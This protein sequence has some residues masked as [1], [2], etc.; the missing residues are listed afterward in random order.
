[1]EHTSNFT[2]S[3]ATIIFK[4]LENFW[5]DFFDSIELLTHFHI[6]VYIRGVP[7][8]APAGV[9]A[10]GGDV[11]WILNLDPNLSIALSLYLLGNCLI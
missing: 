10:G 4:F 6:Y 8:V 9:P 7:A 11:Y 3:L 5:A 1:M 2:I